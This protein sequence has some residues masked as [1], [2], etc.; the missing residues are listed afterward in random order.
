MSRKTLAVTRVVISSEMECDGEMCK[1][2]RKTEI[3]Q[4]SQHIASTVRGSVYPTG[5]VC[6]SQTDSALLG[7][8]LELA[9]HRSKPPCILGFTPASWALFLS[10]EFI[11]Q[12][13]T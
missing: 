5:E 1:E 11:T 4:I 10:G 8:Q 7:L 6:A 12:G 13:D 3:K 2:D 9:S